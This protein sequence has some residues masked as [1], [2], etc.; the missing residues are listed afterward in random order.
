MHNLGG[1]AGWRNEAASPKLAEIGASARLRAIDLPDFNAAR[2]I[3]L[4][5][6]AFQV[7]RWYEGAKIILTKIVLARTKEPR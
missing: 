5:N 2:V 6:C 1:R 3:G 7:S 4:P